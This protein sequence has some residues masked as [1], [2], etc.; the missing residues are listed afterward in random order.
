MPASN[1]RTSLVG[2][3][4]AIYPARLWPPGAGTAPASGVSVMSV[5]FAPILE[6]RR[7]DQRRLNRAFTAAQLLSSA[8]PPGWL[9]T[10]GFAPSSR[11]FPVPRLLPAQQS[12]RIHILNHE[13]ST[14]KGTPPSPTH[15]IKNMNK[16]GVGQPQGSPGSPASASRPR[17]WNQSNYGT[18]STPPPPL[19]QRATDRSRREWTSAAE[20]ISA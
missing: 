8:D 3:M 20:S 14:L 10:L 9:P 5:T 6:E 12:D 1:W 7:P 13:D 18:A 11:V 17:G 16:V 19:S 2:L 15:N 4:S